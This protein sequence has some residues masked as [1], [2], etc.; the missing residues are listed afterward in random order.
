[1]KTKAGLSHFFKQYAPVG[2]Q[3]QKNALTPVN[4]MIVFDTTLN[5]FS[6][7]QAGAWVQLL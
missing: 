2:I 3:T 6:F 7:Y 5:K 4:G 1:M